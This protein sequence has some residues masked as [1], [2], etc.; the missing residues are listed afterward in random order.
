S[1]ALGH[2][3][4]VFQSEI[5]AITEGTN[6]LLTEGIE[7][8]SIHIYSDSESSIRAVSSCKISSELVYQ[9]RKALDN[10]TERNQVSLIWIPGH[11]GIK[12]NEVA[13]ELAR[14][15]SSTEFTGAEP[16]INV[17]SGYLVLKLKE[18]T[19]E[20]HQAYWNGLKTSVQAKELLEGCNR[21][22]TRF[23]L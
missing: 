20:K 16:A 15:G 11:S 7:N 22:T 13:D 6:A 21:R 19:A 4:T 10:L 1:K 3:T 17:Y 18:E 14:K 9:C 23:L 12:G 2:M 5:V 8:K